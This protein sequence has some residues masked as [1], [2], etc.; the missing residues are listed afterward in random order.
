MG[1]H[2]HNILEEKNISF[3][4]LFL[5]FLPFFPSFFS[6]FLPFFLF[7]FPFYLNLKQNGFNVLLGKKQEKAEVHSSKNKTSYVNLK[8][9]YI[10]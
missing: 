6:R 4:F 9:M 8:T 1:N 10:S 7:L 3:L 5:V 2:N